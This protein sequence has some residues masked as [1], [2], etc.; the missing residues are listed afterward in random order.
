MARGSAVE[1]VEFRTNAKGSTN[2]HGE[3]AKAR[4]PRS[5]NWPRGAASIEKMD[6]QAV[7][8][9]WSRPVERVEREKDIYG[10]ALQG[11]VGSE[12]YWIAQRGVAA[13]A[14]AVGAPARIGAPP[15]RGRG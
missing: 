14:E 2:A 6:R 3:R 12:A 1:N 15:R 9:F 10:D 8:D 7:A 13:K 5:T 11:F 4:A